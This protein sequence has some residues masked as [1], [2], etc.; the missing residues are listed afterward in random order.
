MSLLVDTGDNPA[1][2]VGALKLAKEK[3]VKE[4]GCQIKRDVLDSSGR[5]FGFEA[6]SQDGIHFYCVAR[7]TG[8]MKKGIYY[9]VSTQTQFIKRARRDLMPLVIYWPE[10]FYV[11]DPQMI[12]LK[13]HGENVR[14]NKG[15]GI[16]FLNFDSDLGVKWFIP[17]LEA[18]LTILKMKKKGDLAT[19]TG[20]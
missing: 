10:D 17:G 14:A 12:L 13:N 9:I 6:I 18:A 16:H 5:I 11:F 2:G 19:Y 1:H 20:E 8:P 15:Q 7:S 3:L 4:K